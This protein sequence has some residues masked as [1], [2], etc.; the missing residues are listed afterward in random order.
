MLAIC[1]E[2]TVE[3]YKHEDKVATM[4]TGDEHTKHTKPLML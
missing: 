2:I 3:R 1:M 4:P